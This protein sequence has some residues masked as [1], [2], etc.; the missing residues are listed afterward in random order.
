MNKTLDINRRPSG[1]IPLYF[2]ENQ[3]T[4]LAEK[5]EIFY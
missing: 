3:L 2:N 1:I 4:K 5:M